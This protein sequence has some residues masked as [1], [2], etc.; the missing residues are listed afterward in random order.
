MESTTKLYPSQSVDMQSSDDR[1][2]SHNA[3]SSA[4][5]QSKT[6]TQTTSWMWLAFGIILLPFAN[7]AWSI[8]IAAWIAPVCLLRFVRTQRVRMGL[9]VA[10]LALAGAFAIQFRG[11]IPIPG[12]G[13]YITAAVVGV[14]GVIPYALDRLM[15]SRVNGV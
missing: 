13:Y 12:V 14:V 6:R 7:G 10:A 5:T 2:R 11:M 9:P 8:P 15:Y 4:P 3:R 1:T